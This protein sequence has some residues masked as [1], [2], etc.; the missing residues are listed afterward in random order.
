MVYW[1]VSSPVF[2]LLFHLKKRPSTIM[3]SLRSTD[4]TYRR[5]ASQR[6][7]MTEKVTTLKPR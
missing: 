5:Q 6:V 4:E 3:Q 7:V 1:T 2:S